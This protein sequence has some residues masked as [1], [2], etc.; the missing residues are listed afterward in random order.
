MKSQHQ[1]VLS[2]GSNQGQRL[3]TI[4]QCIDVLHLEVGT[5][6]KISP[7]Y[8][9]PAWGFESTPFYNCALVL[10][11]TASPSQVL[12]KILKIEKR[13]GRV[14]TAT[15]GYAARSIDIDIIAYDEIVLD[16]EKL[17][18]PHTLMQDRNFVLL[19]FRDLQLNWIHP[20]F[21]KSILELIVE[22]IDNSICQAVATIPAPLSS[23]PLEKFN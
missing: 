4:I 18:L 12:N 16:T 7:V 20:I 14:R 17:Q 2:L 22:T 21:K 9:S 19:P 3:E 10:H 15:V 6:L 5:V 8:E 23:I 11:T 1:V 13:L